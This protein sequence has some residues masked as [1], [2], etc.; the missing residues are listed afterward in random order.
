MVTPDAPTSSEP[1]TTIEPAMTPEEWARYGFDHRALSAERFRDLFLGKP[2]GNLGVRI[3][4]DLWAT[5]APK[6][7]Y[8]LAALCLYKQ[9]FGFTQEHVTAME[10]VYRRV[11][12][13]PRPYAAGEAHAIELF[14]AIPAKIAAL[15]PPAP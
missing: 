7:C 13:D 6:E 5:E 3:K 1:E 11:I 9:S 10:V 15:L 8:A 14:Y 4:R 2:T 12:S